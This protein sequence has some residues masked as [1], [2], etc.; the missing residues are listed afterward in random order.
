MADACG[1]A[2]MSIKEVGI[3]MDGHVKQVL[4]DKRNS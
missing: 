1:N 2:A 3:F 4:L